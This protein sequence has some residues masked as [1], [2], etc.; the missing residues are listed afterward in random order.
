MRSLKRF[1]SC[2]GMVFVLGICG[3]LAACSASTE[4]KITGAAQGVDQVRSLSSV[5]SEHVN[6]KK[7]T[8]V[9]KSV[10]LAVEVPEAPEPLVIQGESVRIVGDFTPPQTR[11]AAPTTRCWVHRGRREQPRTLAGRVGRLTEDTFSALGMELTREVWIAQGKDAVAVRQR[12][13]NCGAES[14]RLDALVPL[15]CTGPNSLMVADVGPDDWDVLSQKRFKGDLPTVVRPDP[16]QAEGYAGPIESDPFC[17]VHSRRK[18]N[19]PSLLA[20]Y[21]SRLGHCARLLLKLKADNGRTQLDDFSAECEFDGIVLPPGGERTSQWLLLRASTD[22]HELIADFTD[23]MGRY[24]NVNQPPEAAPT[25]PCSWYYYYRDFGEKEFNETIEYLRKDHIPFDVFLIDDSWDRTWGNWRGNEKWP[26][27]M[28]AAADK[29]RQLGYT[30]GIWTCPFVVHPGS[31]LATEHPEWMLRLDDETPYTYGG[32][33]PNYILDPTYPGVCEHLEDTYRRLTNDW[34][35]TYHKLDFM[36]RVVNERRAVFYDRSATR[37]DAY[38]RGLEAI[39]RG[40]GPDVY[41]S[42]CGGHFGGSIG[43]AN[44]Q[45]SG[46]DMRPRGERAVKTFQQNVFRTWMSRLWHVNPD[47]MMVSQP[48]DVG[49]QRLTDAEARTS[50]INQ[51]IGGGMVKLTFVFGGLDDYT[52]SLYRHIIPSVNSSSIALDL[53]EQ[54]C[55]SQFLTRV[56]PR[57]KDLAPWVTVAIVNLTDEPRPVTVT[58]SQE[59]QESMPGSKFFVFDF[60]SQAPLGIFGAGAKIDVGHLAAHDSRLLRIAPW[61]GDKPILAGTDLHFSG[62]GVE[63]TG[64]Q[65]REKEISGRIDT[66]WR[67]PIRVTAAFPADNNKGYTVNTAV[68]PPGEKGFRIARP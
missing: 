15:Q 6:S 21:I 18:D 11:P 67:C 52:R 50:A 36:Q 39:R 32:A 2:S 37:L 9:G 16:K 28:K 27:G 55:P 38:R 25:V 56:T 51:Y 23:R 17:L 61:T 53:F 59:V 42:V 49:E 48:S 5:S 26:S 35:F 40:T 65:A 19:A 29:I 45:R 8:S 33:R 12:L 10:T 64:W 46:S 68:V 20:G 43:I 30:P 54:P 66:K 13:R 60:F 7:E 14:I 4:T 24:H 1:V 57:C 62:G 41:I 47:A 31:T 22:P 63:I 3:L 44:S 34:G 58:L